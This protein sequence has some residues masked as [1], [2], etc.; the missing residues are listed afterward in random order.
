MNQ[1][2]NSKLRHPIDLDSLSS[3]L[4]I[5]LP[6]INL[7]IQINQFDFGQSNPTYYIIDKSL[8]KFVLRKKPPGNLLSNTAHAIERE[9]KILS[10]LPNQFP[11]PKV[12]A[13]CLDPSIIGTPFYLMEFISGRIF[14]QNH[15]PQIKDLNQRT[16]IYQSAINVLAQLH[17]LN[18]FDL[19][20]DNYGSHDDFYQ[21]QIKSLGKITSTQ[22]AVTNHQTGQKVGEIIRK[23]HLLDWYKA[24]K[25]PHRIT[26]IH[27]DYKLDNLV[28]HPTEPRVIAVLDWELSTLGH[29]YSDLANLL[30]P[31]YLPAPSYPNNASLWNG[32]RDLPMNQMPIPIT[33][34]DLL[35]QYCKITK[36]EFPLINW[37]A[38]V[39]FAF[40]RVA[41][42]LQGIAARTAKS[43]ASS[44]Q[45]EE[46][47][48]KF[49]LLA[50]YA[51]ETIEVFEQR[52]SKVNSKL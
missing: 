5:H 23:D 51:I 16:L 28:Y 3:Y 14:H 17:N 31:W 33:V 40:F 12:F 34:D 20:L 19:S 8:T 46:Y 27:G 6:Q 25:P 22:A 43:Q 2:S 52:N 50:Q 48:S 29:P 10:A 41:V 9:F 39:S 36:T 15:L 38:A 1:S 21:R 47:G 35:K 32:F 42:I 44:A 4:K 11:A 49:Q 24:R 37:D 45:A 30:Q 13:L 26:I 18:P 7:P